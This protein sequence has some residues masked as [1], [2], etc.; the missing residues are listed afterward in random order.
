MTTI[1]EFPDS[2]V[3]RKW[4]QDFEMPKVPDKS[5]LTAYQVRYPGN[6]AEQERIREIN[7]MFGGPAEQYRG[8]EEAF[9]D[10][11]DLLDQ[12]MDFIETVKEEGCTESKH[13]RLTKSIM[14]ECKKILNKTFPW[15]FLTRVC[16]SKQLSA[17]NVL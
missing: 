11:C 16:T 9:E 1:I 15:Y 8:K 17:V 13:T 10:A 12:Y 4:L 5:T 3:F 2:P 6:Q 7:R 14:N